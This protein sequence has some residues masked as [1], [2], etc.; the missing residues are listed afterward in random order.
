MALTI[1]QVYALKKYIDLRCNFLIECRLNP[2]FELDGFE[3]QQFEQFGQKFNEILTDVGLSP[4]EIVGERDQ[5]N[6]L[7]GE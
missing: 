4:P 2:N 3:R 1:E 5:T 6:P 7:E